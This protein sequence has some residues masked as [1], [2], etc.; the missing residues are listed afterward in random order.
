[1]GHHRKFD[2]RTSPNQVGSLTVH[3]AH[4][5]FAAILREMS[6]DFQLE[7]P[8]TFER[9]WFIARSRKE[10]GDIAALEVIRD[11]QDEFTDCELEF[12]DEEERRLRALVKG[13]GLAAAVVASAIAARGQWSAPYSLNQLSK[14]A[15]RLD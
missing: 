12:A 9:D 2:E 14:R 6:R 11:L 15:W 13:F 4:E 1:M 5:D 8:P 10:T 7:E 3:L